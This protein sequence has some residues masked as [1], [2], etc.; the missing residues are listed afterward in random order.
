VDFTAEVERSLRVLDGA[1]GIFCGVGGVQPQSE[2]VWHQASRYGV[3]RIGFVNKMDRMGADFGRV[4]EE[5]RKRLGENAVAVYL[6]W[7]RE[8]AFQGVISLLDMK[9]VSFVAETLGKEM[10]E[11]EIPA[12][13]AA[14]AEKAR[15]ELIERLAEKDEQVLDAYLKCPDVSAD[16]LKAGLRRATIAGTVLPV[17]CGS[18]L[19]HIGVQQALDAVVDFLPSPLDIPAVRGTHPK[20]GETV[21]RPPDDLGPAAALVFKV[22]HDPYIGRLA[23]V[24]VYSGRLRKGQNVHNPRTRKR[25]RLSRLVMLHADSRTEVDALHSGE[26]GAAVGLK[27][28][29]TGDTLCDEHAAVELERIRFPKPVMSMA[30][31]PKTRADREKLQEALAALASEDPTCLVRTDE[32][33][34][35]TILSGMGE[36]HLEILRD[37]MLREYHA[38]ALTGKPTVV[39]YEGILGSGRAES[40]FDRTI[41]GRRHY[42]RVAVAVEPRARGAGNDIQ[43]D[44]RVDSI[45]PAFRSSVEEG[46]RDALLTGV[47]GRCPL[48]DVS[49]RVTGGAFDAD[50]SSEVAFR[51]AAVLATRE[52]LRAARPEFLEPIMALEILTPADFLGDVLGDLN[53]RRGKVHEV[54]AAGA[55]Q[56]VRASAP[57]AEMFGFASALRSV[58]RGRGSH[59]MEPQ[60]FEIVPES[61]KEELLSR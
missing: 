17:L 30:I 34:G 45:P 56:V 58:T 25:E 23:F 52:A 2:T 11:S 13:L 28:A 51:T 4:L 24:R 46:V 26:I 44:V 14:S 33:T 27:Q 54:A 16:V 49:A 9:G 20:G 55:A 7:G 29:T 48:A 37:R 50:A 10:R 35:Q 3:P 31:E 32:E 40:A 60:Q 18:A 6:P 39:Y 15:A 12:A 41:G 61:V 22:A 59:T 36:L 47:L 19:H 1:V 8:E 43:F 57:L 53:A 38:E 42:A 21:V 5:I